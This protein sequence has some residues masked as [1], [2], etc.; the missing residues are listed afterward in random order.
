MFITGGTISIMRTFVWR[1]IIFL[2][3]DTKTMGT[4]APRVPLLPTP[5]CHQISAMLI[6]VRIGHKLCV[7]L[8][9]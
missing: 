9:Q 7:S 1:K 6:L 8:H 2:W 5:I 4:L 3:T